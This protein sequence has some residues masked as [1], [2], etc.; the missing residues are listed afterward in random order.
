MT[1]VLRDM[2]V[3]EYSLVPK[4]AN[5][6]AHVTLA[7]ENEDMTTDVDK[8]SGPG[9]PATI[10]KGCGGKLDA[11]GKCATCKTSGG[12][13]DEAA[14]MKGGRMAKVRKMLESW[15]VVAK[16]EG[17]T[18]P[19]TNDRL[20]QEQFWRDWAPLRDAFES[21]VSGIVH[22]D[23][24][25]KVKHIRSATEQFLDQ[26]D[27]VSENMESLMLEDLD[28]GLADVTTQELAEMPDF[29]HK[30]LDAFEST[31]EQDMNKEAIEKAV[32]EA[33][34]KAKAEG[35]ALLAKEREAAAVVVAKLAVLEKERAEAA[36][37]SLTK[38]F[39]GKAEGY[40]L[41][42]SKEALGRVLRFVSKDAALA[43]ELDTILKAVQAQGAVGTEV[44]TKTAGSAAAT[45]A[46][47]ELATKAQA[48]RKENPKL[49]E[50]LAY[51]KLYKE[52]PDA[53]RAALEASGYQGAGGE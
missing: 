10:C 41:A 36:E 12:L 44:L 2:L 38:E 47:S 45:G 39:E 22:S 32:I 53:F 30:A 6:L 43:T 9:K 14:A 16:S 20:A 18:P 29:I 1:D 34:E 13:K 37:V 48:I 15:G 19:L 4:G 31:K 33:V 27:R 23:T 3:W 11:M 25:D 5:P 40:K 7:K 52:D 24:P 50:E 17:E 51:A 8:G 35:A 49:T 42:V 26:L 46:T 28:K 21:A